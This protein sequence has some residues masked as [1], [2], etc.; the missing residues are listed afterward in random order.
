MYGCE[1]ICVCMCVWFVR[2]ITEQCAYDCWKMY[3]ER[4]GITNGWGIICEDHFETE[5]LRK[6]LVTNT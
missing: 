3:F 4:G 6:L 1:C 5:K 2:C